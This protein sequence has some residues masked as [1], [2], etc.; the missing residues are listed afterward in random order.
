MGASRVRSVLG[1]VVSRTPSFPIDAVYTWSSLDLESDR[2][3]LA[4]RLRGVR[5]VTASARSDRR[6][7]DLGT[8]N[9]SI[10]G[11][12]RFAPWIRTVH[13]ITDGRTP[14]DL[15]ADARIRVVPHAAFFRDPAHLPT[16]NSYSIESNLGF[17][18]GLAEHF[19]YFNDDMFLGRPAEPD[20]FFDAEGHAACRFD[21]P[22]PR[23]RLLSRL[24]CRIRRDQ[25]LSTQVFS[26]HVARWLFM[27]GGRGHPAARGTRMLRTIHQASAARASVLRA[28]WDRPGIG[29]EIRRVS[30]RP[31]RG[32]EDVCPFTLMAFVACDEGTAYAGRMVPSAT[33][34]VRDEDLAGTAPFRALLDARPALFCL[35][36]EVD[37]QPDLARV[38]IDALLAEYFVGLDP[39]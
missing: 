3:S 7:R 13:I 26:A 12:L 24:Y 2:E 16:F 22:L 27:K 25:R 1:L 30:A 38:R 33:F 8:L 32:W 14:P 31:F 6:F 35:N 36:D 37:R 10:R 9:W 11:L 20:M 34:F 28:L 5:G 17:I 21:D 29:A 23:H 4:R 19:V 18:S 39:G 15:P